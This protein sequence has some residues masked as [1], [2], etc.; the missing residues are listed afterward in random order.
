MEA[1]GI[2]PKCD[3][4]DTMSWAGNGWGNGKVIPRVLAIF[5]GITTEAA[6]IRRSRHS[7]VSRE[8]NEVCTEILQGC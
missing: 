8:R 4:H 2:W 3:A 7:V 1:A 5:W 6:W